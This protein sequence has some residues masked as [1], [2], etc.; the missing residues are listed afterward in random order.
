MA[1][2]FEFGFARLVQHKGW[3]DILEAYTLN[4]INSKK[5]GA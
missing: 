5:E 2:A 3:A 4:R 1:P